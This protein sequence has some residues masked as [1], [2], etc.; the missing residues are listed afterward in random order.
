[1]KQE[2]WTLAVSTLVT[3]HARVLGFLER[4]RDRLG[5]FDEVLL[6]CQY[7]PGAD[8]LELPEKLSLP[9][10]RVVHTDTKG[11]SASRN[12]AIREFRSDIIWFMDDDVQLS[13]ELSKIRDAITES[14]ATINTFRIQDIHSEA[15]FKNYGPERVLSSLELLRVSSIEIT[16]KREAL[17]RTGVRFY[18]W[19][20]I[21]TSLPGGEENLFLKQLYETGE[22]ARHVAIVAC[23]HPNLMLEVKEMWTRANRMRAMGVVARHYGAIGALLCLRWSTRGVRLGVPLARIG[24][25]WS[26]YII[27]VHPAHPE[28]SSSAPTP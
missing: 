11:I 15:L 28:V 4:N 7:A 20:G 14:P 23:R 3:P 26:S 22:R 21:G 8:R 16:C 9:N 27:G 5:Q 6:V 13:D 10:L 12:V 18:E 17:Q 1:M 19:I 24:E 25:M 2:S